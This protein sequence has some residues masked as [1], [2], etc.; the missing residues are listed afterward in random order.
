ML[1]QSLLKIFAKALIKCSINNTFDDINVKWH[2]LNVEDKN[3]KASHFCKASCGPDG[4]PS[5]LHSVTSVYSFL[6]TVLIIS[7]LYVVFNWL[8]SELYMA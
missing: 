2:E 4:K 3:K 1:V 6:L 7:I 8:T 5:A